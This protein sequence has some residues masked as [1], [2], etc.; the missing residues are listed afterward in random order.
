MSPTDPTITLQLHHR[1]RKYLPLEPISI[2]YVYYVYVHYALISSFF[3]L[4][5]LYFFAK[6][7]DCKITPQSIPSHKHKARFF[8]PNPY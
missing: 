1:I 5:F 6:E 8:T 7:V 3:F 2:Q 4:Y